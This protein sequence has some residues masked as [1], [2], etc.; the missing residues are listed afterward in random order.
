MIDGLRKAADGGDA[1]ASEMKL[2]L[3]QGIDAFAH[4]EYD[5]A[6]DLLD[7]VIAQLAR[8][9]G[10]HAQR[11]VFEDT[12]LEAFIRAERFEEAQQMLHTRLK[13]RSFKTEP[14][15][16]LIG[17]RRALAA[18]NAARLNDI[19]WRGAFRA[20][21]PEGGRGVSDS[22]MTGM[23]QTVLGPVYHRSPWGPP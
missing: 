16:K 12:L 10:S 15:V 14:F 21:L 17:P 8:I 20:S 11:E 5:E 2:P 7:P 3:A 22:S 1:L 4:G 18:P 6:A 23:V 19:L 9:G 13:R